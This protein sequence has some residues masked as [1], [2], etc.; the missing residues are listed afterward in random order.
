MVMTKFANLVLIAFGIAGVFFSLGAL[1]AKRAKVL[2]NAA[3][4]YECGFDPKKSARAPFSLQFFL[5][6]II[7]IIFDVEVALL[8]PLLLTLKGRAAIAR[9]GRVLF[10]LVVLLGGLFHEWREGSLEWA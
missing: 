8:F 5:L 7:F 4:P 1:L 3:T 2:R 9:V 10:F 6:G